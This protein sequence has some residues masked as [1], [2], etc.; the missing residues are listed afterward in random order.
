MNDKIRT[1]FLSKN[2]SLVGNAAI[3]L[4]LERCPALQ[5]APLLQPP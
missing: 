1:H 5:P 3:L 2:C 4:L